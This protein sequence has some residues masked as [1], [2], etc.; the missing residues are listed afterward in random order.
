M[1][2][3][4]S[5]NF[6]IYGL[7]E[8]EFGENNIELGGGL[9]AGNIAIGCCTDIY[10]AFFLEALCNINSIFGKEVSLLQARGGFQFEWDSVKLRANVGVGSDTDEIDNLQVTYGASLFFTIR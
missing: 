6:G 4:G 10:G 2:Q 8:F 3:A 5:Y 1:I 9:K 7:S